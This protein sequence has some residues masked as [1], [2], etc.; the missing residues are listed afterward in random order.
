MQHK[1]QEIAIKDLSFAPFNPPGRFRVTAMMELEQ[2]IK[3]IGILNPIMV[4]MVQ[5]DESRK[6]YYGIADGHR[7]VKAAIG[8]GL[9]TVPAIIIEGL[10][11][12]EIYQRQFIT[13]R[14]SG[15]EVLSV[16]LAAPLAIPEKTRKQLEKAD[17]LYGRERLG[18]YCQAGASANTFVIVRRIDRYLSGLLKTYAKLN[19]TE[20]LI[21]VTDW[22][23]Y[24]KEQ[25]SA[26]KA[27]ARQYPAS[28]LWKAIRDGDRLG[29]SFS[30]E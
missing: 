19:V 20:R 23:I 13:R 22:L 8:A 7:R 25:A 6:K 9:E 11:L 15:R 12:P 4:A 2:D 10:G 29:F 1:L 27:I 17:E 3:K 5:K 28:K 21:V 24:K 14:P 16:F 26:V 30:T 18:E